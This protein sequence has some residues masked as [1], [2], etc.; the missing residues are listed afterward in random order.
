MTNP[1]QWVVTRNSPKQTNFPLLRDMYIERG[2]KEDWAV[3]HDFHYKSEGGAMGARYYRAMMGNTLVGVCV[4]CYPRGLLKDR[5]KLWPNIKPDGMDTKLTNTYRYKWLNA[6]VGLNARTVNDPLF[7]G[8]GVGYRMLNLAAR[9]DGRKWCEIQSSM[10]KFNEFA[11]RAG[12]QFVAPTPSKLHDRAIDFYGLWFEGNP[13]DQFAILEEFHAMRPATQD[14]VLSELRKF[15][16]KHSSLEKTGNNRNKGTSRVDAMSVK[17]VVKN[18]NQLAFST[19]LYGIYRNPDFGVV[20]PARLP[21]IAFD[22]Q[23]VEEPLLRG[24]NHETD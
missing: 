21:L 15:Y 6:H 11:H 3:L 12:F 24:K 20:L 13:I 8:I 7:R 9:M 4:M 5:H 18:I 22:E 14:R 19:P 1:E 16:W 17:D 2:T 10:S 23:G